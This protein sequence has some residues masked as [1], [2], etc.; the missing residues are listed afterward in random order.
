MYYT[1]FGLMIL[2]AL[3]GIVNTLAL[4]A[5]ERIRELGLLRV[6]GMQRRQVRAMLRWEAAIVAATGAAVGLALGALVGWAATRAFD[7]SATHVPVGPLVRVR[8]GPR[9]WRACSRRA[10][11]P[12]APPG[13]MSY[14]PWP[15]NS[16]PLGHRFARRRR[17]GPYRVATNRLCAVRPMAP[18]GSKRPVSARPMPSEAIAV[19]A[20]RQTH[21]PT[22]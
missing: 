18:A 21:S 11:S 8:G 12:A 16:R 17:G 20:S 3:F 13:S 5:L 10:L 7:L 14:A 19:R 1:L 2:I 22:G 15:P 9:W 6:L 4:S